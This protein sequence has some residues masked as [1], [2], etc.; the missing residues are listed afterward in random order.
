MSD[1]D[2]MSNRPEP[3]QRPGGLHSLPVDEAQ[4]A[5]KLRRTGIIAATLAFLI[6]LAGIGIRVLHAHQVAQWT[7]VQAIPTV[8]V[9]TPQRGVSGVQTVLPGDIQAWYEA[10][11]YARVSGYLKNWYFDYGAHVKKGQVLADIDAPDLDADLASSV[12]NLRA[13]QAQVNVREAEMEFAHTT[14]L[15][16]R[17]S[18][19]GVVSEQEQES[20]KADFNSAQARYIAAVAN[21]RADQG[22]VDRL[23][24]LTQYKRLVAPFDGIVTARNTD[25]GALINAGSGAGSAPQLFRVADLHEMRVFVQVPQEISAGIHT[26][27]TA[28]MYLPQ[29]PQRVFKATVATT[30]ESINPSSRTLLVELH[31]DNPDAMLKPG[32]YAEVHFD[33]PGNP[34][35]VRIPTSALLFRE[36][37]IQVAV[38]GPG[39][40]VQLRAVTLG[41]NLGTETEV[42]KGLSVADRVI[43]SP[44]DSLALGDLVHVLSATLTASGP[45]RV[46][47]AAADGPGQPSATPCAGECAALMRSHRPLLALSWSVAAALSGCAVGPNYHT[48]KLQVP[49]KYAAVVATVSSPSAG[50]HTA[51]APPPIELASW[52][53]TLNDPELD[54]LVERAVKANPDVLVA[55][56]RLQEARTYE[57]GLVGTALP[58]AT[59]SG[60]YGRGT[61]DD[62]AR[63][64]ASPGLIAADNPH[65]VGQINAIGGFDAFWQLDV[66]GKFRREIEAAR[67]DAQAAAAA[68]NG[69]LVG[70][71]SDVVRAYVDLRGLQVRASVLHAAVDVLQQSQRIVTIRYE[72]GLT[73]ELDVTLAD[74]EL[75][76]F[77]AQVAP[78]DAQIAAAEYTIATLIGQYPEDVVQELGQKTLIPEVP[79]TVQT[80]L[81][82][83]LLQRRPDI[84]Q[85][86]RELASAN[87][88]IGVA[89]ANLFPQFIVGG[90]IGAQRADLG[91]AAPP[92]EHIW[93][94]GAGAL[95]PLL[96][97]GA[98]DAQVQVA[99]LRTRA[100]LVNYKALI[101]RAVQQVDSDVQLFRAD[102]L[103]LKNLGDALVASQRAVTLANQRYDRGLTDFL[104]VVD[105]E[106]EEY[107]I[108][109]QYVDAQTGLAEQFVA[110]Y[111]DLGGGWQNYQNVP[112]IVRPL[113]AVL[114]IFRDTLARDNALKDP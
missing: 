35:M 33:L 44:P 111:R 85:A 99:S 64:K 76:A 55:L 47:R 71:I 67:Y 63:G 37:G 110:L 54:S 78:V 112:P 102:Q 30:S 97:F 68:R 6:A 92:G 26:G 25:I 74:R 46:A 4:S 8:A 70:V 56:D 43:D 13:A 75:A 18:P 87:A 114:A 108:E 16:W 53:H 15:R 103:S 106:R 79:A 19:K 31:A 51:A 14:Y 45:A 90:A 23:E 83:D 89:T 113:P 80:G 12:A 36:D 96:D 52:W 41:R 77:Q 95:W 91:T 82:V 34:D 40:H 1:S 32:T 39:S 104:N 94:T 2:Q 88:Q 50:E 65:G 61:G 42:L 27:L 57:A 11:I 9:I 21:V 86:E 58:A 28:D 5:R 59:A 100:L 98:L 7:R 69:V 105:A 109:E 24:A 29:Y 3:Q 101:Q 62:A 73:N 38:V 20:K 49:G 107:T 48:P 17:D 22:L 81:P 72:R 93:S 10:P 84:Q 66:F 60:A